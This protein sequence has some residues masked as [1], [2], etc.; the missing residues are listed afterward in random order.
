MTQV[1]RAD[2]ESKPRLFE[3]IAGLRGKYGGSGGE[4]DIEVLQAPSSLSQAVGTNGRL[5]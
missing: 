3:I 5:C 4:G 1:E 2:P